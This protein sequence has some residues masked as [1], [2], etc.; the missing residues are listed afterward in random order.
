MTKESIGESLGICEKFDVC[1]L[2][3]I[4][5]LLKLTESRVTK[6]AANHSG[7]Y[8]APLVVTDT[9]PDLVPTNL[10]SAIVE[11]VATLK[12]D[13]TIIASWKWF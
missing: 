7:I 5:N 1:K 11:S 8:T 2:Y 13:L 6:M 12:T 4:R 3:I 10:H 9:S